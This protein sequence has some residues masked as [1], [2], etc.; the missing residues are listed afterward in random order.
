MTKSLVIV[1][2]PTKAKTITRFLDGKY[3]VAA[4]FGHIRDLPASK[5][6][7]DIEHDFEP[8]YVVPPK[9][10]KRVAELKKLAKDAP[11]VILA[12]DE[13]REGEAIAWHLISALG[14]EKKTI[15]RIAFH[16]ITKT[17]IAEALEHPRQLD[18]HLVDAQQARRILDR[19][20]GYEL[21]P[22]LWKKVRR[23]LSAGRVQSVAVRL[24]V[25]RE[26]E[27]QKF[28]PVE[29]WSIEATFNKDG[30]FI[31]KLAKID[32][33]A[34]GQIG[35]K[36]EARAKKILADLANRPAEIIEVTKKETRRNPAAPFITSTMQ[37]EAARKLGFS[38]KQT[39]MYAQQL[40]E[41]VEIGEE[42]ATGLITYMRTDSVNLS[43]FALESAKQAI[44]EKY[45]KDYLLPEP[46]KYA[47]KSKNAQE[48]HE[49]IR[50]TDLNRDPESV[51]AH[52]DRNQYRLYDLIWKRTIA[53][54]MPEA[55]FDQ[56]SVDTAIKGDKQYI[57]RSTGQ[58]IKFDGFMKVY[59]EGTDEETAEEQEGLLPELAKGDKPKVLKILPKQHFTQPPPRFSDASLI[60]ALEEQGIG[61]PSTYAPTI[62]TIQDRGYVDKIEKKFH[63]TDIGFIVNDILV[64]HFPKVVD[65]QFTAQME[66]QLDQIAEG[67]KEWVPV[68]KEFYGPF[69]DNLKTK[70]K[71]VERHV[72]LLDEKCP[73][74]GN[75]L[76]VK[77]GRFGKFICCSTY[78]ECK[79]TRPL[80][81]EQKIIDD[82]AGVICEKCGK[83]MV[84]KFGRFGSFL[85]CSGYPECKNIKKIVKSTG[86]PCPV[87]GEGEMV[88][89]KSKRGI[90]YSCSK[91]PQCKF[92]MN[93]KP[94][95]EKCPKSGDLLME[96][97]NGVIK[98]SNK[99]CDF[100][101]E[102]KAEAE[103]VE[104][105]KT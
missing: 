48:A 8:T 22:F 14:L 58:V 7:I 15:K 47:S 30:Q 36:D 54:Q 59:L 45:G 41:G 88:E 97:K 70:E 79:Y 35:I 105:I 101:K 96:M 18:L 66:E 5:M 29:Y 65:L 43:D 94:T 1:E 91:Y 40:Y 13:D 39:M 64:E 23:G 44:T 69:H 98:C 25:E 57:F 83:P 11:E 85:G 31:G 76:Q 28:Q 32:G 20:V 92:L 78:P 99:E 52:L 42:G 72:E 104:T 84:V 10:K 9:A 16:E 61:R 55:V 21:S 24:I 86:V 38:A 46:R 68:I 73:D 53:T 12:T 75:P 95:G 81:E 74:C 80:P 100:E 33:Q 60:K 51:K 27:I 49:A 26:R 103:T 37:Q 6:G 87:C 34:L 19:L 62:S 90:F 4:S 17:A 50:P 71:E 77:F 3:F 89:R 56:T 2:S 102:I 82:N 67:E 93:G 63:P